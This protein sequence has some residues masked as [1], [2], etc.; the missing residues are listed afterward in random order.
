MFSVNYYKTG[1]KRV[2]HIKKLLEIF[3]D[4]PWDWGWLSGNPSITWEIVR[5]NPDKPWDWDLLSENPSITWEIVRDNSDK[6][7]NWYWLSDN[8]F[9]NTLQ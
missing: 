8:K 7:W 4:K 1:K 5:D 6:P 3:P 2:N 9:S